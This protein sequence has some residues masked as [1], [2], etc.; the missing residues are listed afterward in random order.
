[1]TES[2]PH[3][4]ASSTASD[5]ELLAILAELGREVS[6]VLDLAALLERIPQLISRLTKFTVFSVYLLDEQRGLVGLA[7]A[8]LEVAQPRVAHFVAAEPAAGAAAAVAAAGASGAAGAAAAAAT[9]ASAAAENSM[10]DIV[11]GGGWDDAAR[12]DPVRSRLL[13]GLAADLRPACS[14]PSGFFGDG[15]VRRARFQ[16]MVR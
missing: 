10:D 2:A 12:H 1:M 3:G 6:S 7:P 8:P 14:R 11:G 13:D 9:A 5:A 15:L 4:A 16:Y